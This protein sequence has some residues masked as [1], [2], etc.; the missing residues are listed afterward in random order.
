MPADAPAQ[1]ADPRYVPLRPLGRGRFGE[2]WLARHRGAAGFERQVALKRL[3]RVDDP[4]HRRVLEAEARVLAMLHHPSIVAVTDLVQVDGG[5]ALIMEYVPGETLSDLLARGTTPPAVAAEVVHRVA[6]ALDAAHHATDPHSGAPVTVVHRDIKPGNVRI[7]PRG[8]VKVLD[9]GL[10]GVP[11]HGRAGGTPAYA[12]PER[13]DG[14]AGPASDVFS[15]GVLLVEALTGARPAVDPRSRSRTLAACLRAVDRCP[16]PARH[17]AHAMLAF[18]PAGRPEAAAVAREAAHLAR[19]LAGPALAEWAPAHLKPPAPAPPATVALRPPPPE[20]PLPDRPWPLLAPFMHPVGFAG[21]AADVAR[22]VALLAS[23]APVLAMHA[24]AGAGKSSFVLAGLVPAVRRRGVPCAV[25]R[26]PEVPGLG[27]RLA[28]ALV[29]GTD[30]PADRLLAAAA[31]GRAPVLVIDQAEGLLWA[32]E[33]EQV[34]ALIAATTGGPAPCRWVL[35]H[36]RDAHGAL[37][38]WL[39]PLASRTRAWALPPVGRDAPDHGR[40]AFRDVIAAPLALLRD[41]RPRHGLVADDADIDRL[42]DGFARL[43]ADAPEAPLVPELQVVLDRLVQEAAPAGDGLRRL[44]VPPRAVLAGWVRDAVADHVVRVLDQ[45]AGARPADRTLGLLLLGLFVAP[46]GD[47]RVWRGAA[48]LVEQLGPGA[49]RMLAGLEAGGAWLV[50]RESLAGVD[51]LS[52]PHDTVAAAVHTLLERPDA[53]RQFG[54]DPAVVQAWSLVDRRMVAWRA[55]DPSG[56]E[57]DGGTHRQI[58]RV[59]A[60]LPWT[61][62]S[63]AWWEAACAARR[64]RRWSWA[65]A[66][67]AV[68][69]VL[70]VLGAGVFW[71]VDARRLE[72]Q[73]TGG[74]ETEALEALEALYARHGYSGSALLDAADARDPDGRDRV[75]ALGWTVLDRRPL[76][77]LVRATVGAGLDRPRAASL[78]GARLSLV[79]NAGLDPTLQGALLAPWRARRPPPPL[80][81]EAWVHLPGGEFQMGCD[82]GGGAAQCR[83][84]D[85]PYQATVEPL[86]MLRHEVTLGEY[87]RFDPLPGVTPADL[88]DNPEAWPTS[89]IS[90]FEANAYAAWLGGRLPTEA[91]WEHAARAGSDA[92]WWWGDDVDVLVDHAWYKGNSQGPEWVEERQANPW[93]LYDMA[94]NVAEWVADWAEDYPEHPV[95]APRGPR[96]GVLKAVRGGSY[97]SNWP[98]TRAGTRVDSEPEARAYSIGFRIVAPAIP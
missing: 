22:G 90:W 73:V 91:E 85:L 36:R 70:A 69:V 52:V 28:D 87:R 55:D 63:R 50:V 49:A 39:G 94:G 88:A 74:T 43:R 77:A 31:V 29:D 53:L 30:A 6:L 19:V 72:A 65:G 82:V 25:D 10:A 18:D 13:Y 44:E 2:V 64:G 97:N 27:L 71:W 84:V 41:G 24:P 96:T 45:A 54:L 40:A 47:R 62:D 78:L 11:G 86:R 4:A 35:V 67:L 15:L 66:A 34:R 5:P 26:Q 80:D 20:P 56:V 92:Q 57:L 21:R 76:E 42:A 68:A 79:A 1:S 32:D 12:A 75:F 16:E 89:E 3:H 61:D 59:E 93:G 23:D 7:T 17:L 14:V 95:V 81:A 60:H 98:E 48:G 58:A 37:Q 38:A 46:S 8:G 83:G 33:A 9:F 51:H